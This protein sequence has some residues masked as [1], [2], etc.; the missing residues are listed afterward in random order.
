MK[1]L[2]LEQTSWLL[3]HIFSCTMNQHQHYEYAWP[4][5]IAAKTAAAA[6]VQAIVERVGAEPT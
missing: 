1:E 3:R 6:Q 4:T 2:L 5:N